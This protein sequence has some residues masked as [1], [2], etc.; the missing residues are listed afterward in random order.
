MARHKGQSHVDNAPLAHYHR[1]VNGSY[2]ECMRQINDGAD[3]HKA[4]NNHRIRVAWANQ[5]LRED[6]AAKGRHFG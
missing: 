6:A 2:D 4:V 3:L 1:K 5:A